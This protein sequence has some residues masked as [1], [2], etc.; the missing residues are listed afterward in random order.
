M[1]EKT[2]IK[3]RRLAIRPTAKLLL[4]VTIRTLFATSV[5]FETVMVSPAPLS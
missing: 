5:V 3:R 4:D 1:A 2:A